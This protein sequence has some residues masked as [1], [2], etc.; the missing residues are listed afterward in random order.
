MQAQI[1]VMEDDKNRS[2][3][4]KETAVKTGVDMAFKRAQLLKGNK[5]KE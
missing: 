1:K 3:K 4:E 2:L 5:P